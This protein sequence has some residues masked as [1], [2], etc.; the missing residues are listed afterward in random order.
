MSTK[1]LLTIEFKAPI[2]TGSV[3]VI[4]SQCGKANCACKKSS[5]NLHGPYYQWS[6]FI[7]GKK[8][9]R[10]LSKE[11]A[12]ECKRRIKNYLALEKK[13]KKII[14]HSNEIAPWN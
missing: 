2:L 3:S 9:T 10:I 4:K 7:D 12:V 13:I 14:D 1:K 8:T 11:M 5:K 6:G